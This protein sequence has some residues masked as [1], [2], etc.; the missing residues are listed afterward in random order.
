MGT[1]NI[2]VE[3]KVKKEA[4]K[5]FAKMGL[6]MSS[7]IKLFLHQSVKENGLPFTPTNNPEQVKARWD[8]EVKEALKNGKRHASGKSLHRDVLG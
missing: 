6:D 2:R 1:I 4:S 3:E 5:T 7:A 8:S